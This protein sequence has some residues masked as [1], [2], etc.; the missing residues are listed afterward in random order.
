[1][2]VLIFETSHPTT[3]ETVS[4]YILMSWYED[5]LCMAKWPLGVAD[6][7]EGLTCSRQCRAMWT[8][9]VK[10]QIIVQTLKNKKCET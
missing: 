6:A 10:R 1:M 5:I 3:S 9:W 4:M 2:E 8:G 7:G